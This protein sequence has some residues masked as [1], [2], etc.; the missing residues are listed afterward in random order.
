MTAKMYTYFS[1]QE[2]AGLDKELCAMLDRARGV[3]NVPFIL[4]STLRTIADNK[5]CGGVGHSA[6]CLGL[7]VDIDLA[8]FSAGWERD[9]ARRRIRK[10]LELAGFSRYGSYPM[11]VHVDIGKDPDY[12]QDV[13]WFSVAEG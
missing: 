7:A 10:G 9:H 13:E 11:H 2:V 1:D 12:T 8:N 4:S 5:A 6:H 3:A